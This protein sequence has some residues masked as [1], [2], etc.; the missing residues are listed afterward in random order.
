MSVF[1]AETPKQVEDDELA[2]AEVKTPSLA[3]SQGQGRPDNG[4]LTAMMGGGSIA[5]EDM[6]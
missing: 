5:V 2:A 3:G 1:N 4:M 6:E